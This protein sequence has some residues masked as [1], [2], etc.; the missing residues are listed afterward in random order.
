LFFAMHIWWGF[1]HRRVVVYYSRRLTRVKV[2]SAFGF[3]YFTLIRPQMKPR[4]AY[5]RRMGRTTSWLFC[6]RSVCMKAPSSLRF[7]G[8]V[9]GSSGRGDGLGTA[10]GCGGFPIVVLW[11]ALAVRIIW[12]GAATPP[13]RGRINCGYPHHQAVRSW[14]CSWGKLPRVHPC[15][16]KLHKRARC[17]LFRHFWVGVKHPI[18]ARPIVRKTVRLPGA[19]HRLDNRQF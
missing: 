6:S 10:S 7:A 14:L 13:Y 15:Y 9:Q 5:E 2:R 16:A 17:E 4:A 18:T 11:L 3:K 19:A 12:G 8:A 1:W